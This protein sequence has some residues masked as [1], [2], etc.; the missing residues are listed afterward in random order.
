MKFVTESLS[1]IC[2]QETR[3][4]F[5][6]DVLLSRGNMPELN[7]KKL[8]LKVKYESDTTIQIICMHK[9]Q[10]H[11]HGEFWIPSQLLINKKKFPVR[12][13]I[14]LIQNNYSEHI[15]TKY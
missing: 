1:T 13:M 14:F 2:G 15:D 10:P 9:L 12:K 6:L 11:H 5:M 3:S 8:H 7:F 4:E